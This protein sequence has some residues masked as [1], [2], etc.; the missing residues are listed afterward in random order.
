MNAD[1]VRRGFGPE[2]AGL[3]ATSLHV[4]RQRTVGS[5]LVCLPACPAFSCLQHMEVPGLG[6]E[7]ELKLK[8]YTTATA[9]LHPS[10]IH[11]LHHSSW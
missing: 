11:S 7:W 10:C 5:S 9:M 8:A 1:G 6:G 2:C 4:C 3:Q